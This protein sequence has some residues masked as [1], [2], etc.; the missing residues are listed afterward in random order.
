[1][2]SLDTVGELEWAQDIRT[3]PI[4]TVIERVLKSDWRSK[5]AKCKDTLRGADMTLH[6]FRWPWSGDKDKGDECKRTEPI[7][8]I[9]KIENCEEECSQWDF[10]D[11]WNIK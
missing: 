1:W 2:N 11:S 7:V 3:H 5:S 9:A 8:P 4:H 6:K 10:Q